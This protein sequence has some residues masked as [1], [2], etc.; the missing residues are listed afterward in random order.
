MRVIIP[1]ECPDPRTDH[2]ISVEVDWE[3]AAPEDRHAG[4]VRCDFCG[5]FMPLDE[6]INFE[7][8]GE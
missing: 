2:C 6:A 8:G 3:S 7:G 4:P 1:R 5:R